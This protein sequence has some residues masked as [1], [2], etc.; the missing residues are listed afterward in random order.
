[1]LN[2]GPFGRNVWEF[3]FNADQHDYGEKE[4]GGAAPPRGSA[5]GRSRLGPLA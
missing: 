3:Q 4:W 5:I 1:M 2:T